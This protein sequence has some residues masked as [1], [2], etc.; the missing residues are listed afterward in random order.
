VPSPW[1][2]SDVGFVSSHDLDLAD[3]YV[4]ASMRTPPPPS[5]ERA[6][7]MAKIPTEMPAWLQEAREAEKPHVPVGQ[8]V[9]AIVAVVAAIGL[10][11]VAIY[12]LLTL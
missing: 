8:I 12:Y 2:R 1:N 4:P 10:G 6:E 9:A 5:R 7:E 3:L 11:L